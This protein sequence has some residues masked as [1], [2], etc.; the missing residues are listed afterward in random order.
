MKWSTQTIAEL[1]KNRWQIE[2]FFRYI[3]Q[4]LHVK[5]FIVTNKNDILIHLWTTLISILILKY[6]KAISKYAWHLSN[7][8]AFIGLNNLSKLTL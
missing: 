7:L 3:K 8:V 2:F 4:L 5:T 1:N 6:L